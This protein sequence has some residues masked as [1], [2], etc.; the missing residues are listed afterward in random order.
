MNDNEEKHQIVLKMKTYHGIH[1][2]IRF[3]LSSDYAVEG[4]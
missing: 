4:Q 2:F 1:L 3:Q